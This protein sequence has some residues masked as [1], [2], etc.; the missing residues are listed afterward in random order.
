LLINDFQ[1]WHEYCEDAIDSGW[2]LRFICG[3]PSFSI[4]PSAWMDDEPIE[5]LNR[6]NA[7][8]PYLSGKI[9]DIGCNTGVFAFHLIQLGL[10]AQGID[11]AST[12]IKIA[13]A[14]AQ[15]FNVDPRLFDTGLIQ[16]TGK[17]D[18]FFDCVHAQ[19]II[20]HLPETKDAID[21]VHRILRPGGLF[22]GGVPYKEDPHHH[23]GHFAYFDEDVITGML[24]EKFKIEKIMVEGSKYP[25]GHRK[26]KKDTLQL[27]WVA[28]KR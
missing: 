25:K 19:E 21:E 1:K 16:N 3:N 18:E 13:Q 24:E 28:R 23:P 22:V 27:L 12:F 20:E 8:I 2:F 4:N 6:Q 17:E 26:S 5:I 15:L 9:L 14:Y 11:G 10:D 7:L